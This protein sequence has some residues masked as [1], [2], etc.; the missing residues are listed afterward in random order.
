MSWLNSLAPVLLYA[1]AAFACARSSDSSGTT[2]ASIPSMVFLLSMRRSVVLKNAGRCAAAVSA[3]AYTDASLI[4]CPSAITSTV[5]ALPFTSLFIE[6]LSWSSAC[7]YDCPWAVSIEV[8][9]IIIAVP[10]LGRLRG[11]GAISNS[12]SQSRARAMALSV[13][14]VLMLCSWTKTAPIGLRLFSCDMP[15]KTA[16]CFA[17]CLQ[18]FRFFD[19]YLGP[20]CDS[21]P[22]SVKS[23]THILSPGMS[24]WLEYMLTRYLNPYLSIMRG[25][26]FRPRRMTCRRASDSRMRR[27]C[28]LGGALPSRVIFAP[29]GERGGR[30]RRGLSCRRRR[31]PW[32]SGPWPRGRGC[33][34][35]LSRDPPACASW[36]PWSWC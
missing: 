24:T 13:P 2:L 29:C 9:G 16:S 18:P 32:R 25:R 22:S 33:R 36:T 35:A 15:R 17:A 8:R 14:S 23:R 31:G 26:A 6:P 5:I 20:G 21:I 1:L 3:C 11:V 19:M 27:G 4:L 7:W 34:P 30:S 10:P 12:R 28:M